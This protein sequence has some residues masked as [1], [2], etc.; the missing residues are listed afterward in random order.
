M[1][2]KN[3]QSTI[4]RALE[5]VTTPMIKAWSDSKIGM[6]IQAQKKELHSHLQWN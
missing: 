4:L 6:T 2:S 1:V 3:T 5:S